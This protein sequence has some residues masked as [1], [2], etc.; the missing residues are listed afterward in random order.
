MPRRCVETPVPPYILYRAAGCQQI[1]NTNT[2]RGGRRKKVMQERESDFDLNSVAKAKLPEYNALFDSNLRHHFENKKRQHQL[3]KMGMVSSSGTHKGMH[4][5]HRHAHARTPPCDESPYLNP[6][7]GRP[8]QIDADGKVVDLAKNRSKLFIIEQ[9]FKQAEKAEF[10]RMKEEQEMRVC[11][12]KRAYAYVCARIFSRSAVC[13]WCYVSAASTEKKA[14]SAREGTARRAPQKDEGGCTQP[15]P[16]S[17]PAT[18]GGLTLAE[19]KACIFAPRPLGGENKLATQRD[20]AGRPPNPTG[21]PL[22]D[23]SG[24]RRQAADTGVHETGRPVEHTV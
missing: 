21:N 5:S 14:R 12:S 7:R 15:L 13:M 1:S 16:R 17:P 19:T 2:H 22:S 6:I 18:L 3:H 9:E 10:W 8:R 4:R 24:V 11:I 20:H 23:N